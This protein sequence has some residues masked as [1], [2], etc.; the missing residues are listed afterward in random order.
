MIATLVKPNSL[1]Y[2]IRHINNIRFTHRDCF[3]HHTPFLIDP[4]H[5][6]RPVC[7]H[8][9]HSDVRTL[10]YSLLTIP[11]SPFTIDHSPITHHS[12]L[13]THLSSL[14]S[15]PHPASF[16]PQ[17]LHRI[18]PCRSYRIQTNYKKCQCQNPDTTAREQ[19]EV[20]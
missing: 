20:Q 5:L 4:C 18:A 15:H 17:M 13:I 8:A 16:R 3:I 6:R 2:H 11:H 12:S 1:F 14:I 9:G 19:P 7:L 10:D